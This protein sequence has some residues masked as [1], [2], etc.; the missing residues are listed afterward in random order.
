MD[1]NNEL[2]DFIQETLRQIDEGVGEAHD[3]EKGTVEFDIAI[4]KIVEKD[5]KVGVTVLGQG[6]KGE[7]SVIDE[8]VSRIKFSA[9][10]HREAEKRRWAEN[11]A[12]ANANNRRNDF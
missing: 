11:M 3:V 4:S 1:Q 8:K 12:R 2:R 7:A 6:I 5:G 9:F 10:M